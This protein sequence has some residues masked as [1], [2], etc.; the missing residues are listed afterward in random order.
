MKK[1]LLALGTLLIILTACQDDAAEEAQLLEPIV[2]PATVVSETTENDGGQAQQQPEGTFWKEHDRVALRVDGDVKIYEASTVNGGQ[3]QASVGVEPFYWTRS[4]TTREISGWYRGDGVESHEMPEIWTIVSNQNQNNGNGYNQSELLYAPVTAVQKVAGKPF[5]RKIYFYHQTAKIIVR[6]KNS[7]V[8]AENPTV[9]QGITI[10]DSSYPIIMEAA[11]TEPATGYFGTWTPT[12]TTGYITP[13]E[14]EVDDTENYLKRYEALL[15]PQ[16]LDHTPLLA[17]NISG[18][19]FY[20]VP[21][22]G[23]AEFM[24]GYQFIYDIEVTQESIVVTP[25]FGG[26]LKWT[27]DEMNHGVASTSMDIA[28]WLSDARWTKYGNDIAVRAGEIPITF[29]DGW[30][31]RATEPED[32]ASNVGD[33]PITTPDANWEQGDTDD[34]DSNNGDTDNTTDDPQW[35]QGEVI[36]VTSHES[37]TE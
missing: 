30:W 10:G 8:L 18:T 14:T 34:I 9:F 24:P 26:N 13:H 20:F 3:L 23:Q 22:G 2:I 15:I 27:W 6:L 12:A 28:P 1:H 7:G 31:L 25:V 32:I 19:V 33:G 35:Q 29:A 11:F 37:N 5:E 21:Q 36:P 17:I 4:S 16:D